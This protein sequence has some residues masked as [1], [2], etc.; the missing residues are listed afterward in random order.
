MF[1]SVHGKVTM[2]DKA[3]FVLSNGKWETV[4]TLVN[5]G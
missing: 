5:S 2:L 4:P 3:R 1:V